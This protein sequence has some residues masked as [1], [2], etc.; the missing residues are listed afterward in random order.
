ME[1]AKR[2]P[3]S[4]KGTDSDSNSKRFETLEDDAR[5]VFKALRAQNFQMTVSQINE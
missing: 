2:H 5:N 3:D 4:Q 1:S